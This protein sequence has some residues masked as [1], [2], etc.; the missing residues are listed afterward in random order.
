MTTRP[1]FPFPRYPRG[2]FQ[3][4]YSDELPRGEVMPLRYF[5]ADLVLFRT[6]SGEPKVLDA[7]CPHLG[8]HLGHGGRVEGDGIVCPFHAWKF[9]GD[10]KCVDI[11]YA[12]KIPPKAKMACWPAHEINGMI[13]VWHDIEGKPPTWFVPEIPEYDS[14]ELT[15]YVRR[16]WKLRTHNQEMAEN[17]VD[18]AHFKYVHGMK[19]KPEPH[20]VKAAYP[21]LELITE[22]VMQTPMGDVKGELRVDCTGFGFSTSRF[23]G[24]VTTTVAASVTAIDDEY[25]D[26]RFSLTVKQD[27][28][29]DIA[30]GVGK[31]FTAEIARQLEED[32]PIWENKTYLERPTLCDGDGPFGVYRRWCRDFY[33]EWYLKQAEDEFLGE[34]APRSALPM[35]ERASRM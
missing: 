29:A 1:R 13:F 18:T 31:A 32:R 27:R 7:H 22:T 23:T 17:A 14:P 33:P 19:V 5:G 9:D 12:K 2:W 20:T 34:V 35:G 21:K 16:R 26:V 15:P 3:V 4:A 8:A 30:R 11:P 24:L 6:E 25:V 10:G 28:G